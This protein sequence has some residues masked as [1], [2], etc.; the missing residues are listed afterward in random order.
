MPPNTPPG[1]PWGPQDEPKG[2]ADRK[3]QSRAPRNDDGGDSGFDDFF[4]DW[5]QRLKNFFGGGWDPK[6]VGLLAVIGIGALVLFE[7]TFTIAPDQTGIVTRFGAYQAPPRPPGLNFMLWPID[8]VQILRVTAE[9]LEEI[10]Y[11]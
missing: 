7:S 10:G 1:G 3:Y 5:Q 8:T 9:N 2:P 4:R 6:T 11:R